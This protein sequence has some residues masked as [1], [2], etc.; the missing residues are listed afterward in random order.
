LA[1]AAQRKK[2]LGILNFLLNAGDGEIRLFNKR[3]QG[4]EGKNN[5]K[6]FPLRFNLKPGMLLLNNFRKRVRV[7]KRKMRN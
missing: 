2:S 4:N 7:F 1:C 5:L 3:M 6:F